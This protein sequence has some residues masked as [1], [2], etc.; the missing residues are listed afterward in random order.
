MP[1]VA[2]ADRFVVQ[3]STPAAFDL[4]ATAAMAARILPRWQ[5]LR[6]LADHCLTVAESAWAWAETNP[7]S[8]YQ[9]PPDVHTGTY[10]I[11][12]DDF[13]DERAWAAVELFVTTGDA[14]YLDQ[15]D[16]G[17]AAAGVP[18]WPW[19]SPFAWASLAHHDELLPGVSRQ[20]VEN[21][22]VDTAELLRA[23]AEQS[24]Y[25][26]AI[27]SSPDRHAAHHPKQ[28]FS[29]GSTGVAASQAMV[30]LWA[31]RLTGDEAYSNAA[32]S[33]LDYILGRNATGYCFVTGLGT[34]SP[35]HPHHRPSEADGVADPV[36][37]FV[38]GG[39][40]DGRQDEPHCVAMY[41][42]LLPAL[43]YVDHVCSYATNEVA[44]NWN[45]ALV[46]AAGGL[47]ALAVVERTRT[48]LARVAQ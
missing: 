28:D 31:W 30:L 20:R 18:S 11:D 4:A 34:L 3:K 21:A 17:P 27:G 41:P 25:R 32:L 45:A 47:D 44:I 39:P 37:G 29:W 8:A 12:G 19:V 15:V 13:A 23:Q 9:Q 1:D 26:V 6:P 36:S 48:P 40:H 5:Q 42:S 2:T 46:Y 16:L 33:N 35:R 38:V 43:A 10:A 7:S 24:A 22:I 14:S